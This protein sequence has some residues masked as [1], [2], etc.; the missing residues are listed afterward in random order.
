MSATIIPF[1]AKPQRY[2][3]FCGN[4][5]SQVEKLIRGNGGHCICNKC[6]KKASELIAAESKEEAV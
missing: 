2:C 1:P 6:V 4:P 5:E 3:A